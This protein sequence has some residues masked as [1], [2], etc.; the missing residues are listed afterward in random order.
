[1]NNLL[2]SVIVIYFSATGTTANV[3]QNLATVL[4]A[5]IYEIRLGMMNKAEVLWKWTGKF[6]ILN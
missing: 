1:M 3:A 5:P 2:S 6:L 4:N